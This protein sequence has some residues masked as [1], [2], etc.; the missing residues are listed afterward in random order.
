MALTLPPVQG[1]GS[2]YACWKRKYVQL[3]FQP[4]IRLHGI[5]FK[6][7]GNFA[8]FESKEELLKTTLDN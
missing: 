7:N 5:V 8:F 1:K 2:F 3:Y 6:D 4:P